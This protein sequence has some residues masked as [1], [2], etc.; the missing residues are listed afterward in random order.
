MRKGLLCG[1]IAV[2]VALSRIVLPGIVAVLRLLFVVLGPA[3]GNYHDHTS[4]S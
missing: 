2:P 3:L 4:S 1:G